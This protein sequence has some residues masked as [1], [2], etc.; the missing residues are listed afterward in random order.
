[1]IDAHIHLDWYSE[2]DRRKI[3]AD[4]DKK[5]L[6]GAISV[7]SNLASCHQLLQLNE[8][9]DNLYVALGWHPEQALLSE[10]EFQAIENLIRKNKE[11]IVAI[12]EVGLPYYRWLDNKS[13]C[14]RSY[15]SVLERFIQLSKEL[16]LPVVLHAIYTDAPIV[17]DLLEAYD[18]KKAH[19]HWFKGDNYT[20]SRMIK[21]GYM[22]S[23]TPDCVYE[24]EIQDLI[25]TY[26]IDKMMIETDGPWN[27]DGPFKNKMTHP[28]MMLHSISKIAEIKNLDVVEIDK[29]LVRN[30]RAFFGI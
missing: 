14:L 24:K 28:D 15:I 11:K 19:F 17:C 22:I 27:F 2:S 23:I 7:A 10:V 16:D 21:N 29:T 4:I 25:K 26:P 5:E 8:E 3:L 18:V 20:I 6:T 30:T 1:M 12:G 9:H 13:I